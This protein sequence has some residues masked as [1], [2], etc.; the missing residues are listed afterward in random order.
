[1]KVGDLVVYVEPAAAQALPV[2]VVEL[3]DGGAV[4]YNEHGTHEIWSEYLVEMNDEMRELINE[5]R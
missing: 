2:L 3:F 1:M 5:S 4:V